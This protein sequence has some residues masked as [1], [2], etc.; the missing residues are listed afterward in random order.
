ML[1]S[2]LLVS[3]QEDFEFPLAEAARKQLFETARRHR[4]EGH[5]VRI[6]IVTPNLNR[7]FVQ[8]GIPVRLTTKWSLIRLG[9]WCRLSDSVHYF[10]TIGMIALMI[11]LLMRS[12]TRTL[13][14]TD[15][16]IFS[17]GGRVGL[18]RWLGRWFHWCYQWFQTYT[19]YQRELLVALS[20]HYE[21]KVK[22]VRPILIES[23][24][25][26]TQKL[27]HPTILYMGHLSRFKGVDIVMEVFRALAHEMP[28]LKLI[29]ASNGLT[30]D[31]NLEPSV[32]C[33]INEYPSRVTLKGKVDVFTEIGQSHVLIYPIRAHSGTFAVPLS[34]Y[35]SLCCGTPFLSSRLEGVAEYFDD[36]F[37][38]TPGD[39]NQFIEKA[40]KMLAAPSE[41]QERISQNLNRIKTACEQYE[42]I[43]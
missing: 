29:L 31:D 43:C 30:Y 36:Y 37:L 4:D 41:N 15:G 11:A 34:L 32:R 26:S 20:P 25:T 3:A 33:L 27:D 17:I 24:A 7:Q 8:E 5:D 35:E 16:G 42:H 9:S 10:G 28:R 19:E 23:P 22:K 12:R 21:S 38:C 14:A 13:T 39:A 6:L 2:I 1:S 40:R 18:R